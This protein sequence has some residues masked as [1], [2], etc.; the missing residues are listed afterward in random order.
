VKLEDAS[1][2]PLLGRPAQATP[3]NEYALKRGE[4]DTLPLHVRNFS[5]Q[6]QP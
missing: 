3:I 6:T 1:G 2:L 5:G 4:V